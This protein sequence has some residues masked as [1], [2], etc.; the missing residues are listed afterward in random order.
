MAMERLEKKRM[1]GKNIPHTSGHIQ[2]LL[3]IILAQSGE[4][5]PFPFFLN[6][7]LDHSDSCNGFPHPFGEGG[8]G[9]LKNFETVV[10]HPT[11][12]ERDHGDQRHGKNGKKGQ[13]WGGYKS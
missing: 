4:F 6:I 8:K 5:L 13:L 7:G 10:D 12:E 2:I 11:E 3:D 9:L 1:R